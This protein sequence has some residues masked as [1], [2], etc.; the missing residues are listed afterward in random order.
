MF[1]L[2]TVEDGNSFFVELLLIR[3]LETCIRGSCKLSEV[4]VV[5][6]PTYIPKMAS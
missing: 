2:R 1:V 3:Y 4:L 6:P 5:V